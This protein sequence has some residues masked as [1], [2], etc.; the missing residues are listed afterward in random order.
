MKWKNGQSRQLTRETRRVFASVRSCMI[1]VRLL[2]SLLLLRGNNKVPSY[3]VGFAQN[4]S[5]GRGPWQP[6]ILAPGWC[7]KYEQNVK[8]ELQDAGMILTKQ[9]KYK[10]QFSSW[11]SSDS[12]YATLVS[13]FIHV[14][15]II[16][17]TINCQWHN[18]WKNILSRQSR[19]KTLSHYVTETRLKGFIY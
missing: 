17:T 16:L 8:P 2:W 12:F 10:V 7:G 1:L 6:C 3:F 13:P 19:P 11:S 4:C 5:G 18:R 9:W 15:F 14:I